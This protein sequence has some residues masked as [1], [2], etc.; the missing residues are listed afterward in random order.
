MHPRCRDCLTCACTKVRAAHKQHTCCFSRA[1]VPTLPPVV[2]GS[3]R[4]FSVPRFSGAP[5]NLSTGASERLFVLTHGTVC[6]SI[7]EVKG[8]EG[9]QRPCCGRWGRARLLVDA[10]CSCHHRWIWGC[11]YPERV[12]EGCLCL[13]RCQ[14]S[15][16]R[17]AKHKLREKVNTCFVFGVR[18]AQGQIQSKHCFCLLSAS[19]TRYRSTQTLLLSVGRAQAQVRKKYSHCVC[20]RSAP[21]ASARENANADFVSTC[22]E[23]NFVRR[24]VKFFPSR[25]L[26]LR[27][28]FVLSKIGGKPTDER[29]PDLGPIRRI[30]Y[31]RR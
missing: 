1:C 20:I 10:A 23:Q 26:R 14:R 31:R 7:V 19:S 8:V 27:C 15:G 12:E 17:G 3:P 6:V 18:P 25:P 2:F 21:S 4:F 9:W 28:A 22:A 13:R 29:T 11:V 24:K 5:I 30:Q 16:W